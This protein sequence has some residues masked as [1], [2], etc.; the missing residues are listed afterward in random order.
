LEDP[1]IAV[2]V[3]VVEEVVVLAA[4]VLVV[5]VLVVVAVVVG[6]G[7]E[8]GR[9][10]GLLVRLFDCWQLS[11]SKGEDCGGGLLAV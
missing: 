1:V 6:E 9:E 5:V 4:V 3:P 7:I 8:G 2:A 11:E 10:V